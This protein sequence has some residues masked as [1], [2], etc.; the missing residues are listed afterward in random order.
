M[1]V[2]REPRGG[3]RPFFRRL[4]EPHLFRRFEGLNAVGTV[5]AAQRGS[6]ERHDTISTLPYIAHWLDSPPFIRSIYPRVICVCC[7]LARAAGRVGIFIL[8]LFDPDARRSIAKG[9][10]SKRRRS[11]QNAR[12]GSGRRPAARA[13]P[14]APAWRGAARTGRG[15]AR[16]RARARECRCGRGRVRDRE[17]GGGDGDGDRGGGGR[18]AASGGAARAGARAR[19]RRPRA[20]LMSS[21]RTPSTARAASC[22]RT[23]QRCR[24]C[25]RRSTTTTAPSSPSACPR[26]SRSR[27]CVRGEEPPSASARS[28]DQ[29]RAAV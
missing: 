16:A 28:A 17:R 18:R 27:W 29:P 1:G 12:K 2:S 8:S 7:A 10:R 25:R 6:T 5:L 11:P 20:R 9:R 22:P 14:R 23:G 21:P 13:R 3:A 24:S 4:A 26:A 19:A 15:R